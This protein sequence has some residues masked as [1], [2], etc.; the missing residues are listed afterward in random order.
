MRSFFKEEPV[1][2]FKKSATQIFVLI[3]LASILGC[4]KSDQSTIRLTVVDGY[5]TQSLWVK[6]FID[7]YIPEVEKR[8]AATGTYQIKWNQAWGG[9]IVK[10]RNVLPGLQKGLGDIGVVTTVFHQD[11]VPIQAIAYVTPF[12]TTDPEL[13]ARTVDEIA[14]KFPEMKEA[15]DTYNQVYLTNMVVLDSYQVFSKEPIQSLSDFK[16]L[17]INGAGTNLRYLHGLGS[18][19]VA[20]SLVTY[21]QNINTGVV[22][23][24]MIW[25]EA[26]VSF[27]MHEVAPYMLKT[28][29]GTVNSKAI[30]VNKRAWEKLPPEVQNILA[31]TAID[32]RDHVAKLAVSKGAES[33]KIFQENGGKIA[34]M[35]AE[36]RKQWAMNMPNI[37]KEWADGLEEK[38]LPGHEIL[39]FYMDTMRAN[40][41]DISRHWDRE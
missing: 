21:F 6:E 35:S 9:Q 10:T 36:E 11:K 8:L 12:V 4:S 14:E 41:Q 27:K 39:K 16:G 7:Y 15:W 28:D 26:A 22:D 13:V 30:T 32:Y 25:P 5:P 37:A 1:L 24:A 38:G 19:G 20:G 34:E 23:A 2:S 31:E 40:G 33:I 3:A 17:K 18:A 29:M